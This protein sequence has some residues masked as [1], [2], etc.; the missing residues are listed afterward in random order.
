MGAAGQ[1]WAGRDLPK[2]PSPCPFH[3]LWQ[4]LSSLGG[5]AEDL[6]DGKGHGF[7][8]DPV[9]ALWGR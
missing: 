9:S 2:Q 7:E 8:P 5:A 6:A 1:S 3:W 4:E